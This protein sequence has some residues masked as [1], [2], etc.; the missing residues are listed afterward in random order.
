[1]IFKFAHILKIAKNQILDNYV[2]KENGLVCLMS[3]G[4]SNLSSKEHFTPLVL[5]ILE[6]SRKPTK[7][8][9]ASLYCVLFLIHTE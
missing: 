9:D 7:D 4:S 5:L 3:G 6:M 2:I 8:N 1:M